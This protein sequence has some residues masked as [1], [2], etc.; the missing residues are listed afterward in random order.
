MNKQTKTITLLRCLGYVKAKTQKN[1][2]LFC[3]STLL[4]PN[5]VH[6]DDP[7]WKAVIVVT[8]STQVNAFLNYF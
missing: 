5:Q 4:V 1:T 7:D 6:N 2:K 3:L 8:E